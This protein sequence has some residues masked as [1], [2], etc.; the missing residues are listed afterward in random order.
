[1]SQGLRTVSGWALALVAGIDI[2]NEMLNGHHAFLPPSF[3]RAQRVGNPSSLYRDAREIP[4]KQGWQKEL[5]QFLSTLSTQ[6]SAG[7]ISH[8]RIVS[9]SPPH[10]M[11]S[12]I[13]IV[14]PLVL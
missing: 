9:H 4:D 6:S 8:P 1:M 3:P 7:D 11:R 13:R 14:H 2:W 10:L 12:R 5:Q